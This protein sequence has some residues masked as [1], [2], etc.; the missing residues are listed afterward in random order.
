MA[1][2]IKEEH[3]RRDYDSSIE[4]AKRVI[5]RNDCADCDEDDC[6]ECYPD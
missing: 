4:K 2:I 5:H 3:V 1:Y 6:G